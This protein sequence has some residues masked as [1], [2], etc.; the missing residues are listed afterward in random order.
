MHKSANRKPTFD[1]ALGFEID[2]QCES[3]YFNL[4]REIEGVQAQQIENR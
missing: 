2:Y 3:F 1:L 4:V